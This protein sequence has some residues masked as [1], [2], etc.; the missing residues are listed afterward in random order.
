MP[1]PKPNPLC[2]R[3]RALARMGWTAGELGELLGLMTHEVREL[4]RNGGG[5]WLSDIDKA[6]RICAVYDLLC[7]RVPPDTFHAARIATRREASQR[8]W[9]PPL[10]YDDIDD[11]ND[12]GGLQW[13]KSR[14]EV[15]L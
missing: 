2:K 11:P 13:K 15:H 5:N 14:K 4:Q 1:R 9:P 12:M 7:M 6:G 3:L 10:A 8:R